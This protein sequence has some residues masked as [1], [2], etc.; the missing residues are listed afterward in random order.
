M[1][2]GF[3]FEPEFSPMVTDDFFPKVKLPERKTAWSY[4]VT[5]PYFFTALI[6]SAK[7]WSQ[8]LR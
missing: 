1:Q 5:V 2:T 6:K 7:F 3:C 4:K 8:W